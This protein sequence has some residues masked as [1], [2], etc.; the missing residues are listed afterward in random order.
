MIIMQ[1]MYPTNYCGLGVRIFDLRLQNTNSEHNVH[2]DSC[3][4]VGLW[5]TW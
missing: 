1:R 4:G 3:G 5:W 2:K